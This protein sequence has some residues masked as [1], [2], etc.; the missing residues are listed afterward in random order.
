MAGQADAAAPPSVVPPGSTGGRLA[1]GGNAGKAGLLG[2][3]GNGPGVQGSAGWL[4][5]AHVVLM[6]FSRCG[7][8]GV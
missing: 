5:G 2:M 1:G 4:H 6:V 8:F 3:V 7:V